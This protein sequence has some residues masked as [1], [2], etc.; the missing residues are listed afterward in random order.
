MAHALQGQV[1]YSEQCVCV[2]GEAYRRV[3]VKGMG[4]RHRKERTAGMGLRV[5]EKMCNYT[6]LPLLAQPLLRDL[7]DQ[8]RAFCARSVHDNRPNT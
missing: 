4:F 6:L 7:R 3:M 1:L 8:R 2:H 5:S